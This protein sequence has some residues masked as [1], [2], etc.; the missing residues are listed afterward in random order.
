MCYTNDILRRYR[1]AQ[2]GVASAS[3]LPTNSFSQSPST[4]DNAGD[5]G[6]NRQM[7]LKKLLSDLYVFKC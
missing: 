7:D 2:S 3:Q 5:R 6:K 4:R 1:V